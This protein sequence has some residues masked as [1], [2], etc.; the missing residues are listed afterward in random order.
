M[1]TIE[2]KSPI[3]S[4]GM[5]DHNRGLT[6][7]E[8]I[9]SPVMM[10]HLRTQALVVVLADYHLSAKTFLPSGNCQAELAGGQQKVAEG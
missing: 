10:S 1:H 2:L 7:K 6:E 8:H 4:I 3:S 9:A 5:E